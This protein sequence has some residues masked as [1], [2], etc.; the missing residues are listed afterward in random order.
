MQNLT[1]SPVSNQLEAALKAKIDGKTKPLGA[2][3]EL[4]NVALRLGLIQESLTPVLNKPTVALFAGDHGI[5]REGVSPYPQEVTFQMVF[6][7]LNG[8]AAI[9]IFA[10]QNGLEVIVVDAGVNFDF[11]GDVTGRADFVT[12][13]VGKSTRSYLSAPAMTEGEKK[14]AL[15]AGSDV[16][17]RLH[18]AGCNVIAFGEMGI[19]NT[20]SSA[21]I[22]SFLTG[23]PVADCVGRGTG[24]D[25][26]GLKRKIEVLEQV[27]AYH[28]PSLGQD[29]ADPMGILSAVGGFEI[30]QMVGGMWRAAANGMVILVDGFISTAAFMLAAEMYPELK[31]YAFYSH[32][33]N[34][35]AHQKMLDYLGGKPL[36]NLGM[37][38]GEGSGAAVAYPL[39]V[40]AA[41]FLNDMAS[42]ESAGV[43]QS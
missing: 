5:V 20:S 32:L 41:A 17:N 21:L 3:G 13:K 28:R 42:F 18:Q 36:L 33:S 4:E 29:A 38:L 7:F 26:D 35:Q 22:M 1:I 6:N 15:E 19:G 9:N 10:R 2:L 27:Y 8:G 43:S 30:A 12:A 11:P 31:G 14:Q 16:V 24:V 40:S 25:D 39:L 34:E 23:T 37:R